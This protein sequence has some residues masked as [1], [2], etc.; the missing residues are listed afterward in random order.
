MAPLKRNLSSEELGTRVQERLHQQGR[1]MRVGLDE[2]AKHSS[3]DDAWIVVNAKVTEGT[4][5]HAALQ[6]GLH[7][8]A[9]SA[10]PAGC[11]LTLPCVAISLQVYDITRHVQNHPGWNC[12]CAVSEL[13]AILRTLGEKPRQFN[14]EPT[15]NARLVFEAAFPSL[16]VF[17]QSCSYPRR[18]CAAAGTDCSEEFASVHSEAAKTRL[19]PF[20]IG[21]LT[22]A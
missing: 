18:S 19:Q 8:A 2:V 12:G 16:E 21:V 4:L 3:K 13:L 15:H 1:L 22:E 20:L 9:V 5:L 17:T 6:P 14:Q 7:Q 11:A 10:C